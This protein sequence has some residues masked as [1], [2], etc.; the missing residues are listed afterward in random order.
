MAQTCE[1]GGVGIVGIIAK[2]V[3]TYLYF[4]YPISCS[5]DTN[6]HRI[7]RAS[8]MSF[9]HYQILAGTR[10]STNLRPIVISNREDRKHAFGVSLSSPR[11]PHRAVPL[12]SRLSPR[13]STNMTAASR[14]WGR[15]M[16]LPAKD[17]D[18][19]TTP[20]HWSATVRQ[21]EVVQ[22]YTFAGR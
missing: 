14:Q 13:I 7:S 18:T 10:V 1:P 15:R 22:W 21:I 12:A 11:G 20:T 16:R 5:P 4:C 17:A 8:P 9:T 3:S 2:V 6:H 19:K